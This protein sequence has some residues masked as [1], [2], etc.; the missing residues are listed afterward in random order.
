MFYK[1]IKYGMNK[2]L[3]NL[4]KNMYE[5]TSISLK[6]NG[7]I[8]PP[9]RTYKG[10]RQGCI[11]S[12]RLFNLFINDIPDIFDETCKPAKLGSET[13]NCLMYADD[14]ILISE[15]EDGL[16]KCLNKLAEYVERW[17]LSI[18]IKKTKIIIFQRGGRLP[19]TIFYL[20]NQIVEKVKQ[21]R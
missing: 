13:I 1:L 7:K 3:I 9:F 15:T 17:Q 11:L 16:Q 6:L 8:T 19:C 10:V 20:G 14:L 12:P 18:N 5:K 4:I 21:Y 2:H